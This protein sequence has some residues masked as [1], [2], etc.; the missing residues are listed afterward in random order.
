MKLTI[1]FQDPTDPVH[2]FKE[3]F[4]IETELNITLSQFKQ[5]IL[6]QMAV[7][8]PHFTSLR[9]TLKAKND[10]INITF[11]KSLDVPITCADNEFIEKIDLKPFTNVKI[12]Y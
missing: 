2:K 1:E 4:I 11:V 9:E 10:K 8:R 3:F 7:D 5:D 6:D 12:T